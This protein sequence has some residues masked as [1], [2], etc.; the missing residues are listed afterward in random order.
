M[1]PLQ[2]EV[3]TWPAALWYLELESGAPD[4][5]RHADGL[6]LILFSS[7]ERA[8]RF[9]DEFPAP[10]TSCL[11]KSVRPGAV[12]GLIR[13]TMPAASQRGRV[14]WYLLDPGSQDFDAS[15]RQAERLYRWPLTLKDLCGWI[16]P[17]VRT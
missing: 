6:S 17:P 2:E 1:E 3:G 15:G 13:R 7:I 14:R 11:P 8:A 5:M 16:D 10:R 9:H 4:V 12:A